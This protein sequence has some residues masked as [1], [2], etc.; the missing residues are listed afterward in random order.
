VAVALADN[1]PIQMAQQELQT[2][3]EAEVVML[4][5]VAAQAALAAREL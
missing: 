3:A 4:V 1:Q 2:Q 5:A